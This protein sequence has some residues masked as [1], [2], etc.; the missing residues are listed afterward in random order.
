[1]RSELKALGTGAAEEA[2]DTGEIGP[3]V[4]GTITQQG[5]GI[6]ERR[7]R[8]MERWVAIVERNAR[9]YTRWAGATG[10]RFVLRSARKAARLISDVSDPLV[11]Q[12][13]VALTHVGRGLGCLHSCECS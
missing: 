12:E 2:A 13:A 5:A 7:A 10:Q 6:V 8:V 9:S 4:G 3:V 11:P 1:M